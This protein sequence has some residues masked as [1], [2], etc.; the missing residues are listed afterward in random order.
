[1]KKNDIIL[2]NTVKQT[3]NDFGNYWGEILKSFKKLYVKVIEL[4]KNVC[5][6]EGEGAYKK[7]ELQSLLFSMKLI[8]YYV[9]K[10]S[11]LMLIY[12]SRSHFWP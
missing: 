7:T 6:C 10:L 11:T 12:D 2:V 3:Q 1:M 5:V 9:V 4:Y 8:K